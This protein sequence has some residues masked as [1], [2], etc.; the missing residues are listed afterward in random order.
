MTCESCD[1]LKADM[2]RLERERDD[3]TVA[4]DS[5]RAERDVAQSALAAERERSG[6]LADL[7][8]EARLQIEYL[9]QKNVATGS[10]NA[11][12]ARITA[13]LSDAPPA[14]PAVTPRYAPDALAGRLQSLLDSMVAEREAVVRREALEEARQACSRVAN[15]CMRG[16]R[17]PGGS[18]LD[19]LGRLA[20]AEACMA[21]V[22]ALGSRE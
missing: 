16:P 10:G 17:S 20:G 18:A 2:D 7:L 3:S 12:L 6:R 1:T 15:E 4:Q 21:A 5:A 14:A 19:T 11:V 22:Q 8:R 9:H 13:A